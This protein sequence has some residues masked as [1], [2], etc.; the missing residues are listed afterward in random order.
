L[1]EVPVRLGLIDPAAPWKLVLPLEGAVPELFDIRTADPDA[2]DVSR[3]HNAEML[4][5]LNELVRAPLF[6]RLSEAG[7]DSA[8]DQAAVEGKTAI[9]REA[10]GS[11][12]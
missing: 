3:E 4:R 11:S 8:L 9:E 2:L 10:A 6:P 7:T 5:L 12:K 1:K